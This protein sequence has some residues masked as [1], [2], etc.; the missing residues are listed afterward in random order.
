MRV[1]QSNQGFTFIELIVSMAIAGILLS[2]AI[3]SFSNAIKTSRITSD[4]SCFNLA[5][6]KARSEAVKRSS[7]ITMCAR[8]SDEKC[9]TDWSNGALVFTETNVGAITPL[10]GTATVD[11][12][13]EILRVCPPIHKKLSITA[14]ASDSRDAADAKPRHH[15]RFNRRGTTNWGTGYIA[16]CDDRDAEQWRALNIG[17][18]GQVKP[19]RVHS[20]GDARIDAFNRKLLSCK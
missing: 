12:D 16:L 19:A 4:T 18:T 2:V 10:L 17:L 6:L 13:S 11:A 5:L 1:D 20:D 7:D 15:I 9:G 14:E 8:E 3:P